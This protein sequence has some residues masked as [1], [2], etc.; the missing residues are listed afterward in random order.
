[1]STKNDYDADLRMEVSA[2]LRAVMSEFQIDGQRPLA[3]ICDT[4]VSAANN[5]LQGY[6]LPRIPEMILL[7]ERTGIT[8]DWIYRGHVGS[9]DVHLARR[10][11]RQ[12]PSFS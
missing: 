3:E 1:M 11:A 6:N 7:A 12:T 10:L 9:I 5:W 4:T 8:L 2:R